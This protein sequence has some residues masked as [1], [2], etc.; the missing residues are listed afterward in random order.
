MDGRVSGTA[1]GG[2][3]GSAGD[4]EVWHPPAR[5][6]Y[7]IWMEKL[8]KRPDPYLRQFGRGG[9]GGGYSNK[10]QVVEQLR[11]EYFRAHHLKPQSVDENISAVPLGYLND[12]LETKNEPWRVR[13]VH[14]Q[15][16]QYEFFIPKTRGNR[17]RWQR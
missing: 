10:F 17:E 14:G 7:E 15:W 16:G 8:G 5:S 4:D 12:A 1:V 6:G 3:G 13:I 2:E 9:A 11:A